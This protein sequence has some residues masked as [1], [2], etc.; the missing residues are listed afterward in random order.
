[1]SDRKPLFYLIAYWDDRKIIG[2][3]IETKRRIP[4]GRDFS[5]EGTYNT[6]GGAI[7]YMRNLAARHGIS[8]EAQERLAEMKL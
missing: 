2:F 3:D 6:R 4:V 8:I 1:M 7:L 5:F